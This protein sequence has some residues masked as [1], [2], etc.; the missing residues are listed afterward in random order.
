MLLELFTSYYKAKEDCDQYVKSVVDSLSGRIL[1]LN[2]MMLKGAIQKSSLRDSH[3]RSIF[4]VD[5][6][7]ANKL[8]K[9][10]YQIGGPWNLRRMN[11]SVMGS[12]RKE[13]IDE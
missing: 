12:S 11:P 13:W 3:A 6:A 10:E 5:D 7:S 9:T 8:L 1:E 4:T 2:K